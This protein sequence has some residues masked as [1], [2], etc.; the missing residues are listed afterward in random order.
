[1]TSTKETVLTTSTDIYGGAYQWATAAGMTDQ[2]AR[3]WAQ[4]SAIR[5]ACTGP[6]ERADVAQQMNALL[7]RYGITA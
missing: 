7:A 6:G 4:R 5:P 1:M 3:R 2:D